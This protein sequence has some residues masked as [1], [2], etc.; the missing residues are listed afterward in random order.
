MTLGYMARAVRAGLAKHGEPALLRGVSCGNAPLIRQADIYAGIGD[1][2]DDNPVVRFD[3]TTIDVQYNPAVGDTFDHPD[4]D[5]KL[6][7]LVVDNGYTR[8][9]I[10]VPR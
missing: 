9:F 5:F 10:V 2:A 6:D 8:T 4:G 7:R 3:I 1:T